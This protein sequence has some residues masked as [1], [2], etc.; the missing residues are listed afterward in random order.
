VVDFEAPSSQRALALL[1]AGDMRQKLLCY[2]ASLT[3][4]ADAEDLLVQALLA[5][6]DPEDG[7]PFQPE[8]GSFQ[9]HMRL[10]LH[11]LA[12]AQRRSARARR[13]E[14]DAGEEGDDRFAATGPRADDSLGDAREVARLRR[15][16][17]RLRG[18]FADD[19]RAAQVFDIVCRDAA[20]GPAAIAVALGCDVREIYEANRRLAREGHRIAAEERSAED[21]RMR[22]LRGGVKQKE[23]T[24]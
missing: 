2:A 15:L 19:D 6:C 13:E 4:D 11:D 9:Q 16:G 14:L 21:A 3:S 20:K 18:R 5:V 1:G 22:N 17:E 24:R 12:R 23:G 7:R 8:R 10:L